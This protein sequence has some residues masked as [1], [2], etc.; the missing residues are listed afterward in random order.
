ME[1]L[2]VGQLI[3]PSLDI[4]DRFGNPAAVDGVPVWSGPTDPSHGVLE[5]ATDGMSAIFRARGVGQGSVTVTVDADLGEGIRQVTG[6]L[7]YTVL[8]AEATVVGFNVGPAEEDP[9]A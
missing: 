5:V 7:S 9:G 8:A 2:K 4:R 3:R 6:I 1:T